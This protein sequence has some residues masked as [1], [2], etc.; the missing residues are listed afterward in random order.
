MANSVIVKKYSD[1]IDEFEA[2]GAITPGMLLVE[3][4]AG[5]VVAHATAD[6]AAEKLFALEDELQGKTISDAYASGD[7]V[8]CWFAGRGDVVNAILTTSQTIAIGDQLVSNGDGALKAIGASP[9]IPNSVV[10]VS[11]EAVTTTTATARIKVR[12]V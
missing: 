5:T 7:P 8:Q 6:G 11:T 10:G 1:V 12:I 2:G 3:G 4:S 9:T